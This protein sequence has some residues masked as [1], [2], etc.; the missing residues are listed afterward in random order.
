M[1]RT[2]RVVNF[3]TSQSFKKLLEKLEITM[4]HIA[5]LITDPHSYKAFPRRVRIKAMRFDFINL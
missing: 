3:Q 4:R 5:S 1:E 2:T